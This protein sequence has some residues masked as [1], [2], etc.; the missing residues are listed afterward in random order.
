MPGCGPLVVNYGQ[1]GYYR[2]LYAP[3]LLAR[4]TRALCAAAADRPDRPA[5]RQLGARPRR[6][7]VARGRA[8]H[9][10]RGAG[11]RQQ[12]P[13]DP[14]R[15]RSSAQHPRH[16]EGDPAHQAMVGRYASDEA[17]PGACAGSAGAPRR[18]ANPPTTGA[19]RRAD[20]HAR[21]PGRSG[22]RRRGQSPLRRQRPVGGRRA[23]AR[24]HPR[25]RRLQ[26]RC[27]D[28]GAAARHGPRRAQPAGQGPALPAARQRPR[29][30]A[31]PARARSRPDRRAGRDQC[32]PDHLRGRPR[33]IPTS[34]S[35]SRSPTA[36]RSRRW[37]MSRRA[38]ATSPASPPARPIRR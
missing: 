28:L 19:S 6:L 24:D 31:G 2:T 16:Y 13:A 4:L 3:P 38:R 22:G 34:P 21:R 27:R 37:S 30:G 25:H 29:R 1:A 14:G 5:R 32:E 7:P 35:I 15:R 11:R 26:C 9:G 10:R 8:R 18:R 36:S 12:P 20:R 17:R 33:P 23:A